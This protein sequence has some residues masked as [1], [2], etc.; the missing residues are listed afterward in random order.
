[1]LKKVFTLV[2]IFT[3]AFFNVSQFNSGLAKAEDFLNSTPFSA[4]YVEDNVEYQVL[5]NLELYKLTLNDITYELTYDRETE[6]FST[7]A[8][9][10]VDGRE[11]NIEQLKDEQWENGEIVIDQSGNAYENNNDV[12]QSRFALP[13]IPVVTWAFEHLIAMAI[14]ASLVSVAVVAKDQIK[15]ELES[16]LKQKNPTIIYRGGSATAYALTPRNEGTKD[17][18][19]L[20]YYRQMPTGK[21]TATTVEAVNKTKVLKAVI[22]GVNHVTVKPVDFSRHQEWRNSK[23]NANN[24]PHEFTKILQAISVSSKN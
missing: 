21:F 19:G 3:I 4:Q 11:L 24:N 16:R 1:M 6:L 23:A 2:L 12:I 10:V 20:S 14:A 17:K 15:V 8:I 18:D 9:S 5:G 7:K 22:D 13:L